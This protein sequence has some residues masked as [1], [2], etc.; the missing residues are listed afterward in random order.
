MKKP[1]PPAGFK[2]RK[3]F[4]FIVIDG[5]T[6]QYTWTLSRTLILYRST[7]ERRQLKAADYIVTPSPTWHGKYKNGPNIGSYGRKQAA[8]VYRQF[9][10]ELQE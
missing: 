7:G 6:L 5:E 1:S 2:S 9:K 3:G 8:E 10:Q 4:G